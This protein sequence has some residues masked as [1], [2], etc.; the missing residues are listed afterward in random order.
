MPC[1]LKPSIARNMNTNITPHLGSVSNGNPDQAIVNSVS[2]PCLNFGLAMY[3]AP[4]RPRRAPCR[5][6]LIR[7]LRRI[8]EAD[9]AGSW[10]SLCS[11]AA[12][13][14]LAA[15]VLLFLKLSRLSSDRRRGLTFLPIHI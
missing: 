14:Q 5:C 10:A 8:S 4:R 1:A 13:R 6:P 12:V 3:L 9:V 15:M 2:V 11:T 7:L